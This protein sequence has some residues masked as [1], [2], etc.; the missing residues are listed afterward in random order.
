MLKQKAGGTRCPWRSAAC[1]K[2]LGLEEGGD[3]MSQPCSPSQSG[4]ISPDTKLLR[5]QDVHRSLLLLQLK[6]RRRIPGASQNSST[7]HFC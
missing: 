6:L 7:Q 3:E 5:P 2:L 1:R 4:S